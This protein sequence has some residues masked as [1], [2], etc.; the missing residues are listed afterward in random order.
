MVFNEI[1]APIKNVTFNT[2]IRDNS[3]YQTVICQFNIHVMS[4][5]NSYF[6]TA[7]IIYIAN[8]CPGQGKFAVR[9]S[10]GELLPKVTS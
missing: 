6:A 2:T 4:I 3:R 5:V 7:A 10:R 9:L 8:T 1:S